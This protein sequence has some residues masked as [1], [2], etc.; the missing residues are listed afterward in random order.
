M[1][2]GKNLLLYSENCLHMLDFCNSDI[3]FY[4]N[5]SIL[6]MFET[7][8][9]QSSVKVAWLKRKQVE[10]HIRVAWDNASKYTKS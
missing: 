5:M 1:G 3:R 10:K 7:P 6:L 4:E 8:L 2:N 9:T